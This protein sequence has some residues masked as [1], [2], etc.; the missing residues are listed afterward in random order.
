MNLN[1]FAACLFANIFFP[2]ASITCVIIASIARSDL[3]ATHH[4]LSLAVNPQDIK[5][6]KLLNCVLKQ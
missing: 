1:A 4:L 5:L 3:L 2:R 6:A